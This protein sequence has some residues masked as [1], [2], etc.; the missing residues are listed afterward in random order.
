MKITEINE[1]WDKCLQIIREDVGESVFELWFSP[2][3]PLNI[4]DGKL[5]LEIPN[6]FFKEWIEDH[7]PGNTKILLDNVGN[8]G[9]KLANAPRNVRRQYQRAV[10][11]NL[12]KAEYLKLK[13]EISPEIYYDITWVDSSGGFRE[14]DYRRYRLWQDTEKIGHP[15]EYYREK[16]FAYIIVSDRYFS[17]MEDGFTA[18]KE[19]SRNRR[20]IRIYKLQ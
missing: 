3:K 1:I 7:I 16:G 15:P 4:F 8:G 20:S 6:R 5:S 2:I 17:V 13:L 14:D 10:E 19:F 11:H 18:I 12:L 9:P